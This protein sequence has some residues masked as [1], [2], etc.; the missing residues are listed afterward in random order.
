MARGDDPRPEVP[1]GTTGNMPDEFLVRRAE[2][3]AAATNR[4][5][6]PLTWGTG[7]PRKDPTWKQDLEYLKEDFGSWPPP[8][9]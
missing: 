1:K 6:L 5:G 4:R 7:Q 2:A 9:E 8:R 3:F